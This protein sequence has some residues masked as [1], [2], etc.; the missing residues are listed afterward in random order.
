L[1][2]LAGGQCHGWQK[3]WFARDLAETYLQLSK[4]MKIWLVPERASDLFHIE[5]ESFSNVHADMVIPF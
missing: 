5:R 3:C 1:W 2:A 4:K